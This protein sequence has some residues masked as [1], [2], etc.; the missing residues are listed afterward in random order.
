MEP[1][2][3][4]LSSRSS[5]K[6]PLSGRRERLRAEIRERL[7]RAALGLFAT[8]G[9]GATT[10]QDI[11]AA[12]DVGKGTFFNYFTSKEEVLEALYD[13]RRGLINEALATAKEGRQPMRQ[14]LADLVRGP[15][16][17]AGWSPGLFRS[18]AIGLLVNEPTRKAWIRHID[19]TRPTMAELLAIGQERGEIRSD[20]P[21]GELARIL[22]ELSFGTLLFWSVRPMGA[23]HRLLDFNL[24]LFW[25]GITASPTTSVKKKRA[26]GQT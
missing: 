10:I 7:V 14:I 25:P 19:Q 22:H 8:R 16:S 9:I 18:L 2:S 6:N 5:V 23:A 11:T 17:K 3:I 24:A 4:K 1:L 12:A 26:I 20:L 13:W 15:V 21:A